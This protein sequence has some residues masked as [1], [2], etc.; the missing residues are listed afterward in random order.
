M[1]DQRWTA[2]RPSSAGHGTE[3]REHLTPRFCSRHGIL[4]C[5][6]LAGPAPLNHNH[7]NGDAVH[8]LLRADYVLGLGLGLGN[9]KIAM[10][11]VIINPRGRKH[12]LMHG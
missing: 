8:L 7:N 2:F 4:F 12:S 11:T 5:S 10:E 1:Q 6:R 3:H 9:G